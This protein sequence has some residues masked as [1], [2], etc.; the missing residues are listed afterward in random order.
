M[1]ENAR[2]ANITVSVIGLGKPTDVD[3][4]LLRDIAA[5]GGGRIFFTEDAQKLPALF[6]QDTFAVARSAFI[7][8]PTPIKTTAG[9]TALTGGGVVGGAGEA[10][11]GGYNL[12]YLRPGASPAAVTVDDYKAP[13]V[14]TWSAGLGRVAALA[15]EADGKFTAP[16]GD[17]PGYGELL[18]S[19]ARFVTGD[20]ADRSGSN[21]ALPPDLMVRRR[22]EGGD[23]VLELLLD[24]DRGL[25]G[26]ALDLPSD[27]IA[28]VVVATPGLPPRRVT[29][30]LRF[31]SP[32]VL[33]A[34]LPLTSADTAVAALDLGSLG[35]AALP[36]ARL[37]YDPEYLPA[38]TGAGSDAADGGA[39]L[40]RLSA[41]TGGIRRADLPGIWDALPETARAV[42]VAWVAWLLAARAAFA[43]RA[44][45]PHGLGVG[46]VRSTRAGRAERGVGSVETAPKTKR[47]RRKPPRRK[48]ADATAASPTGAADTAESPA[49]TADPAATPEV[50][51]GLG[52]AL[53]AA[54][55]R[56]RNRHGKS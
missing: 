43:R 23:L 54:A 44:G 33:S 1:L 27:P 8:E 26:D 3:A 15:G 53:D 17:W 30:P 46:G 37:L 11:A 21:T 24:P 35:H 4:D 10:V 39:T 51:G 25:R 5:R 16:L 45:T 40:D 47:S 50:S 36:P 9:Y 2:K 49:T 48:P 13:F 38:G 29:L 42:P 7:N 32:D 34:R 20:S 31:E 56:S 52:S 41:V 12:T 18:A 14:A 22:V 28:R 19:L 6:A 55:K